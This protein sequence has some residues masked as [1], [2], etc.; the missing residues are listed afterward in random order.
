MGRGFL[1]DQPLQL[2][3]FLFLLCD[4]LRNHIDDLPAFKGFKEIFS[5]LFIL[6]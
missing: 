5:G 3:V 4:T 6:F 1:K 2:V